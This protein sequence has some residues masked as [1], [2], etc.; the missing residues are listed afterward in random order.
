MRL[1]IITSD[2]AVYKN[3]VC[4]SGLSWKG[5]PNNIHALQWFD[6]NTGWIEFTDSNPNESI[7]ELPKWADN[8]LSSW[9]EA[10]TPKPPEPPTAEQNKSI[11]IRL[12]SSTDWVNQPDVYDTSISPHLLNRDAF[13]AYR[14]SIRTIALN[15]VDGD[16]IWPTLPVEIWG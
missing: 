12:L 9:T 2:G 4:Y 8:A 11:A 1:T 13:L 10:N 7:L 5:T 6:N 3:G 16:I 15:P 14:A